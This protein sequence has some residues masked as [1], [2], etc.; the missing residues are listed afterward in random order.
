MNFVLAES[1]LFFFFVVAIWIFSWWL[2]KKRKNAL[3]QK[4][5]QARQAGPRPRRPEP[6]S[7]RRPIPQKAKEPE[8]LDY[9]PDLAQE[10]PGENDQERLA[11]AEEAVRRQDYRPLPTSE[12]MEV[13]LKDLLST[14][15]LPLPDPDQ[16][17]K[18]ISQDRIP[19]N[20]K[21]SLPKPIAAD[22]VGTEEIALW[23]SIAQSEPSEWKASRKSFRAGSPGLRSSPDDSDSFLKLHFPKGIVSAVIAREILDRRTARGPVRGPVRR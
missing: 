11:A 10:T 1:N 9:S 21:D 5:E 6:I 4:Q 20:I 7:H 13:R 2:E 18:G 8:V 3:R 15:G 23:D 17:D 22:E 16:P 12:N 19:E 14:V